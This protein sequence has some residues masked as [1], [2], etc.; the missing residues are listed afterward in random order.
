MSYGPVL[1]PPDR[2]EVHRT[3][4]WVSDLLYS[5]RG[6]KSGDAFLPASLCDACRNPW[7]LPFESSYFG[8]LCFLFGTN[9]KQ[10]VKNVALQQI[11][12][13]A[14]PQHKAF[15]FK[16]I[17]P[18]GVNKMTKTKQ[19]TQIEES[20]APFVAFNKLFIE[21]AEKAM[22]LQVASMQK[23]SKIG[24]D[25][26]NAMFHVQSAEDIKGY[27]EKQQ[28]VA[29]EVAEIV[30]ADVQQLS[31]LNQNFLEDSRKMVEVNVKQATAKAA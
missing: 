25:N 9:I 18:Q 26:M 27:A 6:L 12:W 29:K 30:T 17:K 13:Y 7:I 23:L 16:F 19:A 8:D 20:L 2:Y 24:F 22:G 1:L 5:L 10:A 21:A 28:S 11:L 31:E 4:K 15:P 14:A 3:T